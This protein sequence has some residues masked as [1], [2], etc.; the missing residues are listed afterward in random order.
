[1]LHL[2]LLQAGFLQKDV[3]PFMS[4]LQG[5]ISRAIQG[6]VPA[7]WIVQH[8]TE[9]VQ[10]LELDEATKDEV[11][12]LLGQLKLLLTGISML[13]VNLITVTGYQGHLGAIFDG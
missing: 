8:H 2:I 11:L 7:R 6:V 12:E 13:K 9:G 5:Q 4:L 1:M 3:N 10:S